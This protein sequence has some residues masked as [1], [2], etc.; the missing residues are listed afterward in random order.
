MGSLGV[1][2]RPQD[3]R[4]SRLPRAS[5]QGDPRPTSGQ[6]LTYIW[7]RPG[8]QWAA[9][10]QEP[11]GPEQRQAHGSAARGRARAA[12]A[13]PGAEEPRLPGR[14]LAPRSQAQPQAPPRLLPHGQS[15]AP[16]LEGLHPHSSPGSK[17]VW[18]QPLT[19][20]AALL[21]LLCTATSGC[22]QDGS[23]GPV[24]PAWESRLHPALGQDAFVAASLPSAL[25]T[26][27]GLCR[28]RWTGSPDCLGHPPVPDACEARAAGVY[29]AFY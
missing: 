21:I 2:G 6:A 1:S 13:G 26:A 14:L 17:E 16:P 23:Q 29:E 3:P 19:P 5:S 18:I 22:L 12:G 24:R 7:E 8:G 11:Q 10:A 20:T 4:V 27:A 28:I 9:R 15:E 25:T